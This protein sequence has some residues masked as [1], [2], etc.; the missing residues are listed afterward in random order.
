MLE[1]RVFQLMKEL[2]AAGLAVSSKIRIC[3][4]SWR[5]GSWAGWPRLAGVA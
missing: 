1:E 2:E 3:L 5:T 4:A